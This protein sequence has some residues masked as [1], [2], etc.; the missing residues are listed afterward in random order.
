[1]GLEVKLH[2]TDLDAFS[3]LHAMH[4]L[5]FKSISS[6]AKHRQSKTQQ[7]CLILWF[8]V[9]TLIPCLTYPY[10][11]VHMV[12]TDIMSRWE[13]VA[14][15]WFLTGWASLMQ[16]QYMVWTMRRLACH[17][18]RVVAVVGAGHLQV[19]TYIPHTHCP[20]THPRLTLQRL[21][22]LPSCT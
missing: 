16:D 9:D 7:D 18:S 3:A 14:N 15:L 2:T 17:A 1:M 5:D 10:R 22:V 21:F 4:H 19:C 8:L 13:K 11:P 20:H 12:A 6:E